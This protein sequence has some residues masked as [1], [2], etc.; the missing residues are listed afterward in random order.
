MGGALTEAFVDIDELLLQ[1]ESAEELAG[2]KGVSQGA[3]HKVPAI[4]HKVLIQP[5]P[6]EH[7]TVG[8]AIMVYVHGA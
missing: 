7:L 5:A 6:S 3:L 2:Y 4:S 8:I 1:P